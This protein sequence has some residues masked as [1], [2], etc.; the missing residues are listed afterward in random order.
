M[1]KSKIVHIHTDL[2]FAVNSNRFD[3]DE[4]DNTVII[5]R[6]KSDYDG[7]YK[8][9][10]LFFKYSLKN[11]RIIIEKCRDAKMVVLYDLDFA[12]S[13][14]ANRLPS[15]VIVVW[16]FFGY[17]LYEK[18]PEYV[19]SEQTIK[20]IAEQKTEY[21][22]LYFRHKLALLY[23]YICSRTTRR[24]EFEK[25]AFNRADYFYGV[26]EKEFEFLKKFWPHLPP[27]LQ[28][29][30]TP[31]TKINKFRKKESNLIIIGNNRS[32][33]NNHLDIIELIKQSSEKS[34]YQFL[35]LFNYGQI[36]PYAKAVRVKAAEVKEIEVLEDFLPVENFNNLYSEAEALVINGHIQMALANIFQAIRSN[37]KVYLNE[38]NIIMDSLKEDGFLIFSINDF[39]SDLD[40]HKTNLTEDEVLHNQSQLIKV[41]A[42]YNIQEFHNS[43]LR[44]LNRNN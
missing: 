32:A 36:D 44:I 14:I 15:S 40:A 33:Y 26:S 4:F 35:M 43:L 8:D 6:K 3:H 34:K 37:T 10:A 11:L 22:F 1:H 29:S 12:K 2:K 41:A 17:E 20:A 13:Y 24:A 7:N 18:M 30:Y 42:K 5:I 16:R 23:N 38:K 31:Y 19:F 28:L 39:V 25:A 9:S 27:F 21:N